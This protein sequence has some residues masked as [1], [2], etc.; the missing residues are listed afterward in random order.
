M[1]YIRKKESVGGSKILGPTLPFVGPRQ[2]DQTSLSIRRLWLTYRVWMNNIRRQMSSEIAAW[3]SHNRDKSERRISFSKFCLC[4]CVLK[5][6]IKRK[7]NFGRPIFMGSTRSLCSSKVSILLSPVT[8][9]TCGNLLQFFHF[10]LVTSQII[11]TLF[12]I[13]Y[14]G[15]FLDYFLSN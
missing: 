3:S 1:D 2:L 12:K 10:L 14:F 5:L 6:T 4:F 9:S 7:K 13:N 15:Y 11:R 8:C